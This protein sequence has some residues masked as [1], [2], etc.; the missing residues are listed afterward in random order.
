[1]SKFESVEIYS[2]LQPTSDLRV[3][4]WVS[5]AGALTRDLAHVTQD[6]LC[7]DLYVTYQVDLELLRQEVHSYTQICCLK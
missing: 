6:P 1:M 2:V 4:L 7:R 3:F 5:R